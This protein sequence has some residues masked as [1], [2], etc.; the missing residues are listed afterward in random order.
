[1]NTDFHLHTTFSDGTLTPEE[2]IAECLKKNMKKVGITDHWGTR[3]YSEKFQVTDIPN[4]VDTLKELRSQYKELEIH[5]GLEVDFSNVYGINPEMIDFDGLNQVEYLLFEHVDTKEV[6]GNLVDGRKLEELIEIRS[7][8][9]IPVGLAHNHFQHNF[10]NIGETVRL[11][12]EHDIFL[13]LCEAEDKGKKPV[14]KLL[15]Q[16]MMEIRKN[17]NSA[18]EMTEML[19]KM[20]QEKMEGAV[21]K[22]H[23]ENNLYYFEH[24]EER[25]WEL[26][27]SSELRLSVSSDSHKGLEIG[28]S[29]RLDEYIK[30]YDLGKQLIFS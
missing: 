11:M 3:K 15:L 17:F 28:K 25:T 8:F 6:E 5:I 29:S 2:L 30:R 13:E 19:N 4:Y 10:E 27:Q 21:R 9:N 16:Q 20:K 26:I 7:R 23:A 24:F 12:K 14:D 22:K 1:M 18:F